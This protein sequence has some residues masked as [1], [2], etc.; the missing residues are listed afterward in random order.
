MLFGLTARLVHTIIR[1]LFF[2]FNLFDNSK[3]IEIDQN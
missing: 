2:N 1:G 3:A